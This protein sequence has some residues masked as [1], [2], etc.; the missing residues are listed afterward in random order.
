MPWVE[1]R[2]F[3]NESVDDVIDL[4]QQAG[5]TR[6]WNEPS[7]DLRRAVEGPSS[8]LLLGI[9]DSRLVATVMVGHD[10]HRGWVYYLAVDPDARGNGYG[11]QMM[12]AAE[13][14]LRQRAIPKLNLMVRD[15][16]D[17]AIDFYR[18]LGYHGDAVRVLSRRLD[19]PPERPSSA[20][21]E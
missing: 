19:S 4:W 17:S 10:G 12:A 2:P 15:G 20:G 9:H 18:F 3:E 5:L 7:A 21:P 16:N 1:I 14:W 11:R 13:T 8:A 6:P